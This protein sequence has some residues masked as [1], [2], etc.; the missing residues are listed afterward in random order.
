M[1]APGERGYTVSKFHRIID[2]SINLDEP[3]SDIDVLVNSMTNAGGGREGG[4]TVIHILIGMFNSNPMIPQYLN[5]NLTWY[6]V[7]TQWSK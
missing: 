2:E 6:Y 1:A 3:I 5:N 7:I 4:M